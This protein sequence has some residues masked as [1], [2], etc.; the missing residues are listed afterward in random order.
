MKTNRLL[1][2]AGPALAA[3]LAL[4]TGAQADTFGSG[5]NA[6]T[7]DFVTVGNAGNADDRAF[8]STNNTPGNPTDDEYA[9]PYGGVAYTYRIGV[10]EISQDQIDKATNAGLIDVE[11]GL[12]T[13]SRPAGNMTWYEAAAFV[14]WLNTSTGHQ[15]AYNLSGVGSLSLWSS[16]EAWQA[17][18]E[19]LFR[20][21]DAY[22]FLPSEDEWYKAAYHKNDGVTANYWDWATGSNSVPDG[23]DF[24][25]D[26]TFDAVFF[27]GYNDSQPNDVSNVGL[28]SP[29]GTYGQSGNVQEWAESAFDGLNNSPSE[30]RV[31]RGG[32]WF[33]TEQ[34]L[35]P[36]DR[37]I[38]GEGIQGSIGFR[39]ASVPEP[40]SAA[41]L[42]A[43]AFPL[44]LR[45]AR[46]S[47]FPRQSPP[48][49]RRR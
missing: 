41:L 3:L 40:T 5:S 37:E 31:A 39:V 21:K 15:A 29:Y 22:Y 2:P 33:D 30:S 17:G 23:I 35:R 4:G 7:I 11:A 6:F 10:Y 49:P 16:G 45:R 8:D 34:W 26:T 47:T 1:H 18:G 32:Y 20:H 28:V 38:W 48:P 46:P 44:L 25:G 19:N 27:Q 14:N 9:S 24:S 42:A 36:S 12:W 13:G 43:S